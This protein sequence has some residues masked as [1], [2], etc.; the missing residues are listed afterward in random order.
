M[1][2]QSNIDLKFRFLGLKRNEISLLFGLLFFILAY[3]IMGFHE[4][5]RDEFQAWGIVQDSKNLSQLI[6]N[7]RYEGQPILW[8]LILFIVA[9]LG[10]AWSIVQILH[11]LIASISVGLIWRFSPFSWWQC[12]IISFGYFF[13]FEYAIIVRP[14]G[15]S[16]LCCLLFLVFYQAG[17]SVFFVQPLLLGL[18]ANSQ[19]FGFLIALLLTAL[20]LYSF[21]EKKEEGISGYKIAIP[22]S[23]LILSFVLSIYFI[24]PE[25]DNGFGPPLT[26]GIEYWKMNGV[27]AGFLKVHLMIPTFDLSNYWNNHWLKLERIYLAI[28]G[29]VLLG[30]ILFSLRTQRKVFCFY[31]LGVLGLFAF[32]YVFFNYNFHSYYRHSGHWFLVFFISV[33]LFFNKE[34]KE[35]KGNAS[36]LIWLFNSIIILHLIMGIW[37]AQSDV[38][39][40]FSNVENITSYIKSQNL[41]DQ[42]TTIFSSGDASEV[43]LSCR[44]DQLFFALDRK[45]KVRFKWWDKKNERV[46]DPLVLKTILDQKEKG[47]D[48]QGWYIHT[49]LLAL[50]SS[51]FIGEDARIDIKIEKAFDLPNPTREHF[52]LYKYKITEE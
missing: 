46:P 13:F 14:Y 17:R 16:V 31:S 26:T 19:T 27:L 21:V 42:K 43:G 37:S 52:F 5:W 47:I 36:S 23:V 32:H 34:R 30:T 18:L 49:G 38:R 33:W 35:Q 8:H 1:R 10:G 39:T 24:F 45:E 29:L 40:L 3:G 11:L 9:K 50:D 7:Q 12:L 4:H 20:W 22:L 2:L 41:N 51:F 25:K 44:L 28:G 48:M 15:L 6:F